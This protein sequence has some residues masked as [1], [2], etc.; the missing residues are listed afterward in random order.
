MTNELDLEC[1]FRELQE[2][3]DT[4]ARQH[5]LL[6]IR[7]VHRTY[8]LQ[9]AARMLEAESFEAL[10]R[11]AEETLASIGGLTTFWLVANPSSGPVFYASETARE[12]GLEMDA[13][14]LDATLRAEAQ[15]RSPGQE[16]AD[17]ELALTGGATLLA[18]P[19]HGLRG[20]L[21]IHVAEHGQLAEWRTSRD[22]VSAVRVILPSAIEGVG[23]RQM[24]SQAATRDPLTGLLNRRELER[25][26]VQEA[27]RCTRS[28]APLAVVLADVDHFKAINDKHGHI[29]GDYVLR[30]VAERLVTTLRLPDVVS[31]YGGEEFL[32]LLPECAL[33]QAMLVAE[34]LRIAVGGTPYAAPEGE[35]LTVTASFGVSLAEGTDET[36]LRR[37]IDLADQGLYRAKETGRNLV[38]TVLV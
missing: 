17:I 13:S 26:F 10:W 36:A 24:T 34:R 16:E 1:A 29:C 18:L 7:F 27:S 25:R 11:E 35:E 8:M 28:G 19:F 4:L 21:A 22:L 3:Y 9:S 23:R 33:D 6:S 38:R 30:E 14:V 31:R 32:A 5:Q 15:D 12:S 2:K 37:A 20:G